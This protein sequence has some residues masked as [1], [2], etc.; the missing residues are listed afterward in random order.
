MGSLIF[1]RPTGRVYLQ[2]NRA[3]APVIGRPV[4]FDTIYYQIL[5]RDRRWSKCHFGMDDNYEQRYRARRTRPDIQCKSNIGCCDT[6]V[7]TSRRRLSRFPAHQR[8]K[9]IQ[10]PSTRREKI[11]EDLVSA[12]M[13]CAPVR[14]SPFTN[15]GR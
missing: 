4:S 1:R 2:G 6:Y 14:V 15:R 13:D 5:S 9:I 7:C 11:L 8:P 10:R 12:T 3:W